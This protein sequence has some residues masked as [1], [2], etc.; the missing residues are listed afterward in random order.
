MKRAALNVLERL[1]RHSSHIL[2]AASIST[3]QMKPAT[4]H[5]IIDHIRWMARFFINAKHNEIKL[6]IPNGVGR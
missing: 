5:E 4:A 6:I 2:P 1:V 3:G